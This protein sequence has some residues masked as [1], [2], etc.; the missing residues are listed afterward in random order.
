MGPGTQ[1]V[2]GQAIWRLQEQHGPPAAAVSGAPQPG[3]TARVWTA[4]AAGVMTT[5]RKP[6]GPDSPRCW[7]WH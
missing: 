2:S 6:G 5:L 4:S 7:E 1:Q 3:V